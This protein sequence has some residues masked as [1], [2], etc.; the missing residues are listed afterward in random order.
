MRVGSEW[1]HLF[2]IEQKA[3]GNDYQTNREDGP[4][5]MTFKSKVKVTITFST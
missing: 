3:I 4:E 5:E 1:C 2:Y